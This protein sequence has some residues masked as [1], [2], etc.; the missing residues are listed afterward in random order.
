MLDSRL[1]IPLDR[2]SLEEI[3]VPVTGELVSVDI[4]ELESLVGWDENWDAKLVGALTDPLSKDWD[5]SAAVVDSITELL[6]LPD[7]KIPEYGLDEA[8]IEEAGVEVLMAF[9]GSSDEEVS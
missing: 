6:L 4:Y 8:I 9:D 1:E 7:I 3:W 2:T 5:V